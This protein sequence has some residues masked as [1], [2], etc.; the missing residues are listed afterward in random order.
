MNFLI[1][2]IILQLLFFSQLESKEVDQV[3]FTINNNIY[4]TIDL[5]NRSKY[6]KLIKKENNINLLEDFISAIVFDEFAKKNKVSFD[7]KIINQY[8]EKIEEINNQINLDEDII[9][10]NIKLDYQRKIILEKLVSNKINDEKNINE[11]L[12]FDLYNINIKY[13]IIEL[14]FEKHVNQIIN[15][16]KLNKINEIKKYL[17]NNDIN[18]EFYENKIENIDNLDIRIKNEIL[19]NKNIFY[20]KNEY[21][22][23][24]YIEKNIKEN[25]QLKFT[26]YQIT[27]NKSN[28]INSDIINCENIDEIQL[29]NKYDTQK[30]ENLDIKKLNQQI[31][32]EINFINDK[33]KIINENNESVIILCK[34]D[35]DTDILEEEKFNIKINYLAKKIENEFIAKKK[36]DYNLTIYEK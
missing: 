23:L 17:S 28:K 34:I 26:L 30:Y 11:I 25:L 27:N 3:I 22:L 1:K 24:G 10:K 19:N 2:L 35:Y 8:L 6:L 14:N 18:Y 4:T 33:V 21:L 12:I 36:F 29:D 9:K 16:L 13:F 7:Q 15:E 32:N 31:K 5:E 20:F